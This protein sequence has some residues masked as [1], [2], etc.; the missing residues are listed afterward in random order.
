MR[1]C[2]T[3]SPHCWPPTPRSNPDTSSWAAPISPPC[4]ADSSCVPAAARG[5]PD[6]TRPTIF[7]QIADRSS[8]DVNPL[9]GA[10]V[11]ALQLVTSRAE[12]AEVIDF[13]PA[14]WLR[15]A[16]GSTATLSNGSRTWPGRRASAGA[17]R[18]GTVNGSTLG[19]VAQNTWWSGLQ[20][21]LLGTALSENDLP[22]VGTVLP[23]DDVDD[24][25]LTLLG[26]VAE[27]LS[28]LL[29]LATEYAEPATLADWV[30]RLQWAVD[31]FT[32]MSAATT[33]GSV[34]TRWAA[35]PNSAS[36]AQVRP[37]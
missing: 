10:L 24:G 29:K 12:A 19:A 23:L 16:S 36:A 26:G 11:H 14:L 2:A 1:F 4:T 28:R 8:A 30:V 3:R 22:M 27:L 13:A 15:H 32:Q 6:A 20:R 5:F 35:S 18:R 31:A 34:P 25:D 21:M 37:P 9:V 7:V 33:S 17:C